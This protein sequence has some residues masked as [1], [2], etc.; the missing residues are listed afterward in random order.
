[1]SAVRAR[2][3]SNVVPFSAVVCHFVGQDPPCCSLPQVQIS[4]QLSLSESPLVDVLSLSEF[5]FVD[6]EIN[7]RDLTNTLTFGDAYS[8]LYP[9]TP[10]LQSIEIPYGTSRHFVLDVPPG[11]DGD[12]FLVLQMIHIPPPAVG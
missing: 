8:P 9:T 4:L 2:A 11:R 6:S 1:M 5:R 12:S 10:S 3:S 7:P